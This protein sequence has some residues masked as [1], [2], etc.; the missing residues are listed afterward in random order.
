MR[1]ALA[2]L[3][4]LPA[5]P[6]TR[7]ELVFTT[8]PQ[9]ELKLTLFYPPDWK[10][11][12][13]RPAALFFFGGGFVNGTPKQFFS[14]AAYLASRG[15]VAA[16]AEY[17]VK[18]RHNTTPIESF[19]DCKTAFKWLRANAAT[20]GIDPARIAA[21]GG[22]AGGTCAMNLSDEADSTPTLLLLYNSTTPPPTSTTPGPLSKTSSP[23]SRP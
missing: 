23:A 13:R 11:S 17:R 6:I 20:H 15:M 9:G 21:G 5:F 2:L 14:T 12:D 7:Q 18:N 19:A 3:L 4:A 22:S 1:L 16:S 8:T 10:P